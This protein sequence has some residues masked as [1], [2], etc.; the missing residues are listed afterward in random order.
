MESLTQWTWVWVSSGSWWWTEWPGVLQSTGLQRVGHNWVTELSD[1]V[2]PSQVLW[3]CPFWQRPL[4]PTAESPLSLF[5]ENCQ[6][7]SSSL[8][9]G[10]LVNISHLMARNASRTDNPAW[11]ASNIW[12]NLWPKT[13]PRKVMTI[14]CVNHQLYLWHLNKVWKVSNNC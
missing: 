5:E 8:R 12:G 6:T 7:Q 2:S 4:G 9:K 1:W 3:T 13:V 14:N 10:I 11:L